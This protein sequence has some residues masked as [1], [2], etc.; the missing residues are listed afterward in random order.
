MQADGELKL[1][2]RLALVLLIVGGLSYAAFSAPS[3]PQPVR[4]MFQTTAGKVLFTH[5]AHLS[6][7]GYGLSCGDCHHTLAPE[8]YNKAGSCGECHEATS[9][10][11][12]MPGRSDAFH[13]QCIGCHKDYG[14]GPQ[15]C[16]ACHVL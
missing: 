12:D 2:Y 4:L 3:P 13:S 5:K 6:P 11:P 15:A 1:A 8:E 16:A 9:D 14:A 7:G 10:D